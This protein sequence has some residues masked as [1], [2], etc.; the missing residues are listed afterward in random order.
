M[1]SRNKESVKS[2]FESKHML[3]FT[4]TGL[5]QLLNGRGLEGINDNALTMV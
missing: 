1:N 3:V 5:G 4:F 2:N